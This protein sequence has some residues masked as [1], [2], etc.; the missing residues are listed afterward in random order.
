MDIK[1]W[2]S[3]ESP[4]AK[5]LKE[6]YPLMYK[7]DEEYPDLPSDIDET[8]YDSSHLIYDTINSKNEGIEMYTIFYKK[9]ERIEIQHCAT[10]KTLLLVLKA[11]KEEDAEILK[12]QNANGERI[13]INLT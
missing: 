9:N 5:L 13:N 2:G 7:M 12:V 8:T 10:F 11:F 4:E 6:K 3:Y 1:I